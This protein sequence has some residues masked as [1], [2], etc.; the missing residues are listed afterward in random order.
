MAYW[1]AEESLV[2][3]HPTE[4]YYPEYI[5]KRQIPNNAINKWR[6]DK[7][8]Q[9]PEDAQRAKNVEQVQHPSSGTCQLNTAVSSPSTLIIMKITKK[10]QLVA[11]MVRTLAVQAWLDFKPH[12]P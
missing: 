12:S 3:T 2:T 9:F 7:D 11:S 4:D 1:M 10:D 8:R 6:D 5:K